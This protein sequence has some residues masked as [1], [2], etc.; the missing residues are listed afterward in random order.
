LKE[1]GMVIV[2]NEPIKDSKPQVKEINWQRAV[3]ESL[4]QL[5]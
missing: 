4:Q 1:K 5:N 2:G 3:A